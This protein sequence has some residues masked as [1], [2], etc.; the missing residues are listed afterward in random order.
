MSHKL[1]DVDLTHL[2]EDERDAILKVLERD[3]G[4]RDREIDR[5]K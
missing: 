2:N 5:V 3:D 1:G 4:L